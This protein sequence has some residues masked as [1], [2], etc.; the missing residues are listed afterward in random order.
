MAQCK[1]GQAYS[2]VFNSRLFVRSVCSLYGFL[3]DGYYED[4]DSA[5]C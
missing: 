1:Y 5:G 3:L 4:C 2:A